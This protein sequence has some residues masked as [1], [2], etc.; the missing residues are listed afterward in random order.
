MKIILKDDVKNLGGYGDEVNVADGYGRNFLLPQG[1]ALPATNENK[2]I[3]AQKKKIILAKLAKSK[4]EA[5]ALVNELLAVEII[6]KRKVGENDKLFGSVTSGDIAEF[7]NSKGFNI[8][9]KKI[10]L[11]DSIKSLGSFP[12]SLKI[13]PEVPCPLSVKVDKEE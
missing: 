11:E 5:E 8:D 9:K 13:H 3:V 7:L 10:A 4:A 1:L 6:F 2:A 12:V